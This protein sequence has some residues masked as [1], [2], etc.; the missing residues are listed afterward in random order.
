GLA[1]V[2]DKTKCG[3]IDA[4]GQIA[5]N[6]AYDDA[7]DFSEGFAAVKTGK[8]WKY[9]NKNGAYLSNN[10]FDEALP[11]SEG[12]ACVGVVRANF[13]DKQFGGYSGTRVAY[14]FIDA[15]GQYVIQPKFLL[16]ESFHDGLSRVNIPAGDWFGEIE[17]YIF[18]DKK[19]KKVS[20]RLKSARSFKDGL[21][22]V[23]AKDQTLGFIDTT[24]RFVIRFDTKN[25]FF[26]REVTPA[27]WTRYGFIDTTGASVIPPSYYSARSFSDGVA[28]VDARKR[29]FVNEKGEKVIKISSNM[30][31][32]DFSQGLAAA[33]VYDP[34]IK[35]SLY[36]YIDKTGNFVIKPQFYGAKKFVG[37]VAAVKFTDNY[38]NSWGYIDRNGAI[39][40]GEKYYAAG[41][42]YRGLAFVE[43]IKQRGEGHGGEIHYGFIDITGTMKIDVDTAG[44]NIYP[45]H[46]FSGSDDEDFIETRGGRNVS[47]YSFIEPV[48]AATSKKPPFKW[49][50]VDSTGRFAIEPKYDEA[51]PFSE[52]LA[53]VKVNQ[54]WGYIDMTGKLAI[55]PRYDDAEPFS[56]G[57]ALVK[58]NGKYGYLDPS[59][60]VAI[61]PRFFDKTYSFANG[62]ALVKMNNKYGFI[63]TL[64]N[65]V[66]LPQYDDARSFSQGLALV[67]IADFKAEK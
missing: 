8:K 40:I 32:G 65:F 43:Y 10:E 5:I 41:P 26:P 67:G 21:A 18:I 20:K 49:G 11:F 1:F 64:G 6:L 23:M 42:F 9:I 38:N 63:D 62:L 52:G 66:V 14:G 48:I 30:L 54:Q 36:G 55:E 29:G 27:R 51:K 12:L 15:S 2:G 4:S 47:F 56:D 25:L 53:A 13:Y 33:S 16:A 60:A 46:S 31:S 22:L 7:G 17:D 24:G 28:Y 59:G 34:R 3:Y 57:R 58:E 35:K 61:E 45:S 39:V 50:Y 19:E 44:F 37:D